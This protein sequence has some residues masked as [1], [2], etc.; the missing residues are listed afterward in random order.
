MTVCDTG[1]LTYCFYKIIKLSV[2]WYFS[3]FQHRYWENPEKF[4]HVIGLLYHLKLDTSTQ[5]G[6]Y[7]QVTWV[8]HVFNSPVTKWIWPSEVCMKKKIVFFL[9]LCQ[10]MCCWHGGSIFSGSL[11]KQTI[12]YWSLLWNVFFLIIS[13]KGDI[14]LTDVLS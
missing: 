6:E 8:M 9:S 4:H 10:E 2:A 7:Q 13:I 14:F 1:R 5:V 3:T 12:F 11:Y